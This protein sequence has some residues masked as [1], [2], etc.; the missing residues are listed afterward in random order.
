MDRGEADAVAGRG[1]ARP[2]GPLVVPG[3]TLDSFVAG[4]DG[5]RFVVLIQVQDD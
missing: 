2:R 5:E 4:S 1:R 3:A